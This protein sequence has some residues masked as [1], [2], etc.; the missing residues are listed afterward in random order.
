MPITL[1]LDK[2]TERF[3]AGVMAPELACTTW[4][5]GG[6]SGI[7]HHTQARAVCGE[8]LADPD[9]RL[10]G[11]N[12]AYDMAV[13]GAAFPDLI[14][15]IF[16]AYDADRITDTMLRE[17]LLD[18]AQGRYRGHPR[19]DGSWVKKN[20]DLAGVA[21]RRCGIVLEKDEWR[22]R[23]GELIPVPLSAWPEGA[24]KYATD[25]AVATLAVYDRQGPTIAGEYHEA[26]A[27]FALHLASCWGL[28]TNADSVEALKI[29][30]ETALVAIK[31]RL[32]AAGLVRDDGT[33]DTKAAAAYMVEVCAREGLAI[34][35]TDKGGVCLDL[36][37][38][39]ATGDPVLADYAD[40]TGYA[41]TLQADV[42]L[43]ERATRFPV[44]PWYDLAESGR[45]TCSKPNIQNLRKL[46]GIRECFVPRAGKVFIQADLPQLELYTLAQCCYTWLGH[47]AL[48]EMLKAGIDPHTAFAA[49]IQRC[50]YQEGVY[51]K[52]TGD[53]SFYKKRQAAKAFNFGKPGGL[54]NA[55]LA[56][57]AA[58]PA[59]GVQITKKEAKA[60]SKEW[61][62][63][64]PEMREYFAR[65]N[66]LVAGGTATV[67]LPGT[68][69]VRGGAP[70]C[71]ACN[72]GFQGLGA[73]CAKRGV[74]LVA[75]AQYARPE[76][77]LYGARTVAFV[78][79]EIIAEADEEK[80]HEAAHELARLM[81]VGANDFL[82][83]VP[84]ALEKMEPTVMRR[85]SKDATQV[86]KEGRLVPW[87]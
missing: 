43:L 47:S 38:C 16:D 41:K 24:T 34:R 35:R 65:V 23:F 48:G 19:P 1:A 60:Y 9:T 68:G 3:R 29:A 44:H 81:V 18:I 4:A 42:V 70:Y 78:H 61:L 5:S 32:V 84:I 86:W 22:L 77:P 13:L 30:T 75:R 58:S 33:R 74:Y 20:Y 27:A 51:L 56:E 49:K 83:D 39:A 66:A 46:P 54:G 7:V 26:R 12:V 31:R 45:T 21:R 69:F 17:K 64:F 87:G 52:K 71:A 63:T 2:E 14:P 8:W 36:D 85:W 37:A 11:H 55:T 40:Y 53:E 80:C 59:Y 67:T 73:A 25:D 79:D 10:V 62:E 28:R 72:T 50:S 6:K 15:A 76:S 57:L 82:P